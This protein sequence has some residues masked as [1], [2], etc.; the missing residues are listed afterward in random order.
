MRNVFIARQATTTHGPDLRHRVVPSET[1]EATNIP[2]DSP[3]STAFDTVTIASESTTPD[4]A[5]SD[6][7]S[8]II[9]TT[10]PSDTPSSSPP[11]LEAPS[12]TGSTPGGKADT[13]P[14]ISPNTP[15]PTSNPGVMS[16]SSSNADTTP[17]STSAPTPLSD[18]TSPGLSP[19]TSLASLTPS[20]TSLAPLTIPFTP[21]SAGPR[22]PANVSEGMIAGVAVG[23]LVLFTVFVAVYLNRRRKPK[24]ATCIA[25]AE[26]PVIPCSPASV[27]GPQHSSDWQPRDAGSESSVAVSTASSR[28][29]ISPATVQ[30]DHQE[31]VKEA[32]DVEREP[33]E[34]SQSN[35][36]Q[37]STS[38]F[39]ITGDSDPPPPY[40]ADEPVVPAEV[41]LSAVCLR[42][43]DE[44]Q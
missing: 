18:V 31:E 7:S 6:T 3:F 8:D 26:W 29:C 12:S 41:N 37:R 30:T 11:V 19:T 23:V 4:A 38:V 35:T 24:P 1:I 13:A 5:I 21:S 34:S 25:S 44:Q 15:S 28:H 14:A 39:T 40:C 20:S 32:E 33:S 17:P 42:S 9:A 10:A 27:F 22:K 16:M 2:I 36:L 43:E